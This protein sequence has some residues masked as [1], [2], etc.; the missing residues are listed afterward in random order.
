[1]QTA[2]D[3]WLVVGGRDE[4]PNIPADIPT[5]CRNEEV[6]GKR[7]PDGS[8]V[9]LWAGEGYGR[10]HIREAYREAAGLCLN[11]CATRFPEAFA[12]CALFQSK[13]QPAYMVFGGVIPEKF[14]TE[15]E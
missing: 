14:N 9:D 4:V 5:P 13:Y 11:I 1:M 12:E 15:D 6:S 8:V 3:R 2:E 10:K 7:L